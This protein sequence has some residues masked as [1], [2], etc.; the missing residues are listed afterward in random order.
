MSG[1]LQTDTPVPHRGLAW[2]AAVTAAYALVTVVAATYHEPWRDEVVPLSIARHAHSLRE[3]AAPLRFEG[4]PLGWYALLWG[5]WTLI[6]RTWVLKAASLGTAVGAVWLLARGPLPRWLAALV[7][8]SFVPLYQYAVV[9][10]G[11]SLEMLVLFALCTLYPHRR[12]HPCALG[13][14]LAALANTEAFGFV[15]AVATAAMLAAEAVIA[16]AELRTRVRDPWAWAGV[17]VFVAGL[18]AA[19]I[20]ATP[21]P[22]HRGTGVRHLD[23]AAAAAGIGRAF[24]FPAAHSG[25][26]AI[27]PLPSLWVWAY[28]ACLTR[29]PPLLCFAA[30]SLVGFEA[31]FN[32]AHGPGAPWHVGNVLLALVATL[33]LDWSGTFPT[34]PAAAGVARARTWL[35]RV[36]MLGL[37]AVLADHVRLGATRLALEA[38]YDHS[39]SRR[40]AALLHDDPTLRD[41]VVMGEPDAPLWSLPYYADDRIYLAREDVFRDWGVFAP[42]RRIAYDLGALLA[43][44]RR[45]HGDCGCPVVVTLGFDVEQL[46]IH[47]SFGGTLFAQTFEITARQRDDF[48]AATRLVAPLRGPTLTDERYDVFVLR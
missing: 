27:V 35:G 40:L 32:L 19:A 46:G 7:A 18:L 13:L 4:H 37:L 31:I 15:M 5:L 6:G 33:W 34:R 38:R 22:A 10:R 11:Y 25:G 45:V 16:P 39:E 36:L 26:L 14:V 23:A 30:T 1:A 8:F 43:A 44:A 28:F 12:A 48:L 21:D 2:P 3:L 24:L 9:S 41:A 47:T 20:V 29:T 17:G 42:P